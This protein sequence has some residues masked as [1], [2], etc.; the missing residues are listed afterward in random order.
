MEAE[1]TRMSTVGVK[2][3]KMSTC[4]HGA[5]SGNVSGWFLATRL[6]SPGEPGQ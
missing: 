6:L 1:A 4:V 2:S 5:V 3:S